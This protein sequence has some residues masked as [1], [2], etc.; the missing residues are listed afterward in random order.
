MHHRQ[1]ITQIQAIVK[2]YSY[3]TL[4]AYI[5]DIDLAIQKDIAPLCP[6]VRWIN[7]NGFKSMLFLR[8]YDL[9]RTPED[10]DQGSTLFLDS[11]FLLQEPGYAFT[12]FCLASHS[13]DLYEETTEILYLERSIQLMQRWLEAEEHGSVAHLAVAATTSSSFM[14]CYIRENAEGALEEAIELFKATRQKAEDAGWVSSFGMERTLFIVGETLCH[15]YAKGGSDD[16]LTKS[17]HLL[18]DILNLFTPQTSFCFTTLDIIVLSVIS[19]L[20]RTVEF[21]E[22]WFKCLSGLHDIVRLYISGESNGTDLPDLLFETIDAC[23]SAPTSRAVCILHIADLFHS[24]GKCDELPYDQFCSDDDE[25]NNASLWVDSWEDDRR[26]LREAISN[27]YIYPHTVFSFKATLVH[28]PKTV[29][30]IL[31]QVRNP[32]KVHK[33]SFEFEVFPLK[34]HSNA[35]PRKPSFILSIHSTSFE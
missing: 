35:M 10:I 32:V 22:I 1:F 9:R 34:E 13:R 3:G 23:L 27:G 26:G 5:E 12:C 4:S 15:R 20:A 33:C 8:H 25:V 11:V 16:D 7:R 21:S 17:I 19:N 24:G 28:R 30:R 29:G 31:F 14:H 18:L 2:E 6:D